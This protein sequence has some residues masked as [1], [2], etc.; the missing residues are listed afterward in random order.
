M[1]TVYV[2]WGN[3]IRCAGGWDIINILIAYVPERIV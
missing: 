3:N 2:Q 1:E